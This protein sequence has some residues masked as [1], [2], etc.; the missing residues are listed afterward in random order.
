MVINSNKDR[1]RYWY[2]RSS[3]V[4]WL[5]PCRC[6]AIAVGPRSRKVGLCCFHPGMNRRS[7]AFV[8]PGVAKRWQGPTSRNATAG[9]NPAARFSFAAPNLPRFQQDDALGGDRLFEAD[10]TD[11]LAGL[12]L[13]A[14]PLGLDAENVGQPLADRL[15]M[16]QE[17]GPLG[18]DDAVDVDDPPADRGDGVQGGGEHLGRVAAAVLRIGV[19]KHLPDVAQGGGAQQGVGHRVQE[20]VGVS[21]ADGLAVVR[22]VDAA[23]AQGPA[24]A[25][26]VDVVS[27]S[28]A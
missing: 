19:G 3:G 8:F 1:R 21:V 28:D 12:A 6:D 24:G 10:Q 11:V 13:Q 22:D 16:R 20:G 18:K 23:Q 25:K 4:D 27:E 7:G 2:H 5:V 14:D 9:I 17:L 15:A 26:P